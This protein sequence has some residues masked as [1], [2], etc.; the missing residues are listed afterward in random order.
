VKAPTLDDLA[1]EPAR[2]ATLTAAECPAYLATLAAI[3]AAIAA[4]LAEVGGRPTEAPPAGLRALLGVNDAAPLLGVSPFTLRRLARADD[5]YRALVF[6]NGTDRL[7]FD[8]A[9]V[10]AFRRR[11]TGT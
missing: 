10:E 3:T 9:K 8:P 4:R 6:H 5:D 1:R 11:R 7:L 2:A